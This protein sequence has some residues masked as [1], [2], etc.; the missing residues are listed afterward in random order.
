MRPFV[1]TQ[2]VDLNDANL[3][4]FHEWLVRLAKKSEHL[5]VLCLEKGQYALPD[6]VTVMSLGKEEGVSHWV[7]IKRFYAYI[8]KFRHQY[9][10]VFVH[11]NP[12]YIILGGFFWRL[13]GHS[14]MLW[15]VHKAVTMRLWLAE[16]F[17]THIVSSS[18][19]SYRL[20]SKKIIFAGHGI[21]TDD[22]KEQRK[23]FS[24]NTIALVTIGR[25]APSKDLKTLVFAI[26][27]LKKQNPTRKIFLDIYGDPITRHDFK[28][29]DAV[30]ALI[31]ELGLEQEV[32]M[33]GG[34][35]H[36]HIPGILA[37]YNLF[38]HASRTGSVDKVVLE[39]LA[40]G[41]PAVT[42]SG[43]YM[44]EV[45]AKVVYQFPQGDSRSLA[46]LIEKLYDSGILESA[47]PISEKARKYAQDT[48]N[49][50]QLIE[51]I[52]GIISN[53]I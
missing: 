48:Y 4:F 40:A 33:Q 43:A 39:A 34:I 25:I 36:S 11:M 18:P 15:Y 17:V 53:K 41:L 31:G 8:F 32:R 46:E 45:S 44:K 14:V 38:V 21:N 30:H 19:E 12:E 9:D 24:A 22:F 7:Y 26:Y 5:Y 47:H 28:Y 23:I 27:Y 42:S 10:G 6:N 50:D 51:K 3:S 1:I 16:K 37:N 35:V 13:T 52:V 2:K 20:Q 49:L 29:A